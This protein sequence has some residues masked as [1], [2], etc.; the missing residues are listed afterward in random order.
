MLKVAQGKFTGTG[1]SLAVTGLGFQPRVLIVKGD[2]N[3]VAYLCTD[4]MGA[5][6]AVE[7]DCQNASGLLAGYVSSLDVDGFTIGTNANINTL[8][9]V[10]YYIAIGDATSTHLAT[11]SYTGTGASKSITGLGF[12]PS[13]VSVH[14]PST[15]DAACFQTSAMTANNSLKWH[16]T[17]VSAAGRIVSLDAGG[18]TLGTDG[19]ANTNTQTYYYFA[20]AANSLLGVINYTGD[21][22]LSHAITGLG[23]APNAVFNRHDNNVANDTGVLVTS[24]MITDGGHGLYVSAHNFAF[25]PSFY[26]SLDSDGFTT[27]DSTATNASGDPIKSWALKSGTAAT[28]ATVN[29]NFFALMR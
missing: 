25:D 9:S 26:V 20:I 11:G 18:F 23:I 21:G 16:G 6:A 7:L 3:A 1:S 13:V 10:Y 15:V 8:S 29:S 19:A 5:N 28:G 24:Q 4:T 2:T 12:Q 14:N 17:T 22:T 27:K